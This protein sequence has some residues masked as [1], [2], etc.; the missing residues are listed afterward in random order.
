ML[1]IEKKKKDFQFKFKHLV[2]EHRKLIQNIEKKT[3]SN[4]MKL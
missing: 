3:N 1:F 4:S 2:K